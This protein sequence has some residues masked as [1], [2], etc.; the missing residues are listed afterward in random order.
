[1]QLSLK[2]ETAFAREI[3]W[4]C[5]R[6]RTPAW[7]W[8]G[9][10]FAPIRDPFAANEHNL[11]PASRRRWRNRS[12][13]HPLRFRPTA[14][15]ESGNRRASR[16]ARQWPN[17]LLRRRV[18]E[19][20]ERAER[21]RIRAE[22]ARLATIEEGWPQARL[23]RLVEQLQKF[24]SAYPRPRPS[25]ARR[26]PGLSPAGEVA[27]KGRKWGGCLRGSFEIGKRK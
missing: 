16:L 10:P 11:R 25:D 2:N 8:P 5:E 1:V 21:E 12:G 24:R 6:R 9:R 20:C 23:G 3:A 26:K 13:G 18:Q 27:D 4:L 22:A 14:V 17:D 7:S 15:T 19:Q